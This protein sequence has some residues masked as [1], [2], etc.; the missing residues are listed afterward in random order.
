MFHAQ[1]TEDLFL[2]VTIE[3]LAAQT[4]HHLAENDE[5]DVA[6]AELRPGWCYQVFGV[7]ATIS[8]LESGPVGSEFHVGR[9]AGIMGEQV[10]DRHILLAVLS[11]L[12]NVAFHG[13]PQFDLALLEELHHATGGRDDLGE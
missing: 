6:I 4:L 10:A 3:R 7:S 1:R 9:Q 2:R 5:I 8:F 11:K 13:I 12:R